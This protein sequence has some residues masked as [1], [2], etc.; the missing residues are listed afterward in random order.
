MNHI[1]QVVEYARKSFLK[2]DSGNPV[3]E[4]A[5]KMYESHFRLSTQINGLIFRYKL[6]HDKFMEEAKKS[7]SQSLL[8]LYE[9]SPCDD[10][11]YLIFEP[12]DS[13]THGPLRERIF[14]QV[15]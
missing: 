8:K 5:A 10:P 12:F 14:S 13:N 4:E 7:V 2:I 9:P 1:W 11:H 15:T 6:N 3:N